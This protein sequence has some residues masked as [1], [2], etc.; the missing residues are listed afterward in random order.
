MVEGLG[1]FA[2]IFKD[3]TDCYTVIGGAA[4]DIIM[5]ES[6]FEFRETKDIDMILIVENKFAEFA[7]I[8]WKFIRDG[9]YKFG[10]KNSDKMQFF[11]F[12]EPKRGYPIQIELFSRDAENHF[13]ENAGIIP[14]HIDDDVSSLSAILLDDNY[15][16]LMMKGR[17]I[18]NNIPVLDAEYL[19]IF[20][21]YAFMNLETKKQNGEFVKE[22]DYKKHKND[23][24]RLMQIIDRNKRIELVPEIKANVK[25]FCDFMKN[26][27]ISFQ[28][29]KI[30]TSTKE[31]DLADI[32][33]MF[34]IE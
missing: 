1:N 5:S 7:K 16:N 17:R 32:R 24:F 30:E 11:R 20:K 4:C 14:V 34:F 28:S 15:Y 25:A 31:E 27:N 13:P 19:M 23:V 18:V 3:Y 33:K 29:L 10:W 26:V 8:F 9:E 12:T 21:M 22:R 2:E 6:A